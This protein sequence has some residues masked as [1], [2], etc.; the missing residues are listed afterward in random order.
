MSILPWGVGMGK[1]KG[2]GIKTPEKVAQRSL[3]QD[4]SFHEAD[5]DG[6]Q[7]LYQVIVC[8][9]FISNRWMGRSKNKISLTRQRWNCRESLMP[10]FVFYEEPCI[11][12]LS[13]SWVLT[14]N[15][16]LLLLQIPWWD[17]SWDF[18]WFSRGKEPWLLIPW[19]CPS[20]PWMQEQS[21]AARLPT[22]GHYKWDRLKM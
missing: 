6:R 22:I 9:W 14:L 4:I 21:R 13:K 1:R 12:F 18:L 17:R 8:R 15:G 3:K 16:P 10:I 2:G 20:L 5:E 19:T 7:I 11:S